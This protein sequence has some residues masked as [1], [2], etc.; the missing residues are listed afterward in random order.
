MDLSDSS[1][2]EK[3]TLSD[4]DFEVDENKLE[5]ASLEEE[6]SKDLTSNSDCP[7]CDKSLEEEFYDDFLAYLEK[8]SS[9]IC[10]Y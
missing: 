10:V 6:K 9:K 2:V 4:L 1:G 3:D 8:K 5:N 7:M